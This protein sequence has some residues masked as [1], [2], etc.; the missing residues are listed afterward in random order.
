MVQGFKLLDSELGIPLGQVTPFQI[1][2]IHFGFEPHRELRI[3]LG[4]DS[5][6]KYILFDDPVSYRAQDERDMLEYWSARSQEKVSTGGI[7][8][9]SESLYLSELSKGVSSFERSL[10]HYLILGEDICVEV[11]AYEPPQMVFATA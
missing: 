3:S 7:Y 1:C 11:I 2:E 4:G 10:S 5:L 6:L 9:I 8:Q